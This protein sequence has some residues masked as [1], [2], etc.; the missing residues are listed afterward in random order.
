MCYWELI[1]GNVAEIDVQVGI[2]YKERGRISCATG[3]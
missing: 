2:V 3:N 1:V